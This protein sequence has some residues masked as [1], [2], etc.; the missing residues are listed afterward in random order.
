MSVKKTPMIQK[1]LIGMPS[2][3]IRGSRL[4]IF[5]FLALMLNPDH[6][7]AFEVSEVH[8]SNYQAGKR[9]LFWGDLHVHT[10]LSIDAY[11]YGTVNS[12]PADA[13]AFASGQSLVLPDKSTRLVLKRPLDFASVTDHAET[14]DIMYLCTGPQFIDEPFCNDLRDRAGTDPKNSKYIFSSM[15]QPMLAGTTPERAPICGLEGINCDEASRLQWRR[16]QRYANEANTPCDFTAF[17]GNEWS[18]T[19]NGRHWHRNLIFASSDVTEDAIDYVRYQTPQQMRAALEE[20]CRPEENCD[21][22]AIPHNTNLGDGGGF[23]VETSSEKELALQAK[24]ERLIE[25]H[26]IK[27]NS[28][29]VGSDS[30]DR[31]GDCG[32][33]IF[34]PP[35]SSRRN[36]SAADTRDRINSSY[37]R[38]VLTRGLLM[39][40]KNGKREINPLQM[41]FIA[42]TD[43]HVAAPGATEEKEWR[44]DSRGGGDADKQRHLTAIDYNPGGLVAVW[45]EENTR[46]S[47]F[48]SMKRREVYGTSGTRIKL[49]FQ[50]DARQKVAPCKPG[51]DFGL[52][53]A[54]GGAFTKPMQHSPMFSVL[55]SKD[56]VPISQVHIVKGS[57]RDGEMLETVISLFDVEEG[58]ADLCRVWSDP[59]FDPGQPAYWYVRV[60]EVPSPRWS[61][62]LCESLDVCKQ[63]PDADRMIQERAWSSPIWYLPS[64][65][66]PLANIGI[67]NPDLGSI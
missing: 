39:Y 62:V 34:I 51:Y 41:G 35:Y 15:I 37:A 28:E 27:G 3:M 30:T 5:A 60:L 16:I 20:Q 59:D 57:L 32:F 64:Q 24:Y 21:V 1:W 13:F 18:A 47:I 36:E 44:G 11:A 54:M 66:A 40:D 55:V 50:A 17:I 6:A 31:N 56:A 25:V 23:D 9:N 43:S 14:F 12:T 29:C 45:S 63:F 33:E 8:C 46:A 22:I 52:S 4:I 19:P 65:R 61:K 26:Q 67:P 42:S 49:R 7:I 10:S 58:V 38:R 53:T 2:P 48:A